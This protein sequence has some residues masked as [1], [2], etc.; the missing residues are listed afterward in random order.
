MPVVNLGLAWWLGGDNE[1]AVIALKEGLKHRE[2]QFGTND[3][4]SFM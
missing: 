1:N 3:R 2:A 4:E